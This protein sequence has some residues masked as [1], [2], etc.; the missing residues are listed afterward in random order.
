MADG[1]GKDA[2]ASSSNVIA[3]GQPQ[4]LVAP[5]IIRAMTPEYK[6][7][8][9]KRLKRKIDGRLLPA[10]IIM[11]I[12]NYIDRYAFLA[13]QQPRGEAFHLHAGFR[14]NI[15]AAALAGLKEDLNLQG[16]E[17]QLAVSILFVG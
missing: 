1:K 13:P 14:N 3:A 9:E 2:E 15:A 10:I 7:A 12:L 11:Y 4:G 16:S 5:E 17:F 6:L 8:V